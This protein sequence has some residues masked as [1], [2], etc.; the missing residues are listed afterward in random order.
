MEIDLARIA[1]LHLDVIVALGGV[2][3]DVLLGGLAATR[4][5]PAAEGPLAE[6]QGT[7]ER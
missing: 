5:Q 3:R 1:G 6:A 4:T 2:V 7:R